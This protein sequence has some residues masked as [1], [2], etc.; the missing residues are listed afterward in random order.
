M[1][2]ET[3]SGIVSDLKVIPT[4]TGTNMVTFVLGGKCCKAFGAIAATLQTLNDDQVEITAKGGTYGGKPEYTVVSVTG[5]VDGREVS[6]SDSRSDSNI[7]NPLD[8]KHPGRHPGNPKD[9]IQQWVMRF[10]DGLTEAEWKSW[11]SRCDRWWPG[12]PDE[13][14]ESQ[15]ASARFCGDD[16]NH[17]RRKLESVLPAIKDRFESRLKEVRSHLR[18]R[19]VSAPTATQTPETPGRAISVESPAS[20]TTE[21]SPT[22]AS[23]AGQ[24]GI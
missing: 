18:E 21:G 11:S 14:R 2:E 23:Q 17:D 13:T 10:I 19:S 7:L 22:T 20:I 8:L 6:V 15:S 9:R 24:A 12:Y 4:R 3:I 5:T 16:Y 1:S